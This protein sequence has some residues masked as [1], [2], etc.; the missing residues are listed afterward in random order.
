LVSENGTST[1]IH[2]LVHVISGVR[3]KEGED[4]IAEGLAE[5]YSVELIYRAGGFSKARREKIFADL[6][7]WG[8]DVKGLRQPRSSGPVTAR[9]A[10]FFDELDREIQKK[11]G[12]R[13][14]L[15]H[16][17]PG[18][19][20]TKYVGIKDLQARYKALL[21]GNSPLLASALVR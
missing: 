8:K 20:E 19:I 21:Q 10:A 1:V 2:E 7:E 12:G 9:A 18:L 6:Q 4:W 16:L 15:D 17:L 5:Y 3:G 14:R 11:S 13:H